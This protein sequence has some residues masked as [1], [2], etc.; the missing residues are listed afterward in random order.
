ML[1]VVRSWTNVHRR[2][3]LLPFFYGLAVGRS[4]SL[5]AC[6]HCL[7]IVDTA[8]RSDY[9]PGA[10]EERRGEARK[11]CT[12]P[13]RSLEGPS[14]GLVG[15]LGL[16]GQVG[17]GWCGACLIPMASSSVFYLLKHIFAQL[18][19][20]FASFGLVGLSVCMSRRLF[21]SL[22]SSAWMSKADESDVASLRGSGA[23][24]VE[25]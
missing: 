8:G 9:H 12:S 13:S 24:R 15:W 6:L 23:V 18:T 5:S 16:V 17:L 4:V 7:P 19:Y 1:F 20:M 3:T 21:V 11:L 22:I 14:V 2:A 10:G 25:Y